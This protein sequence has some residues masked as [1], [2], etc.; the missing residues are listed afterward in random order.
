M[1]ASRPRKLERPPGDSLD[2]R[3][4]VLARVEDDAVVAHA[5][6]AVIETADELP[7]DHEVDVAAPGR[8]QVRVDIERLAHADQAL[9]GPDGAAV[10]SRP[11]DRPEQHGVRSPA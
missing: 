6:R 8:T 9:L 10:P 5:S 11:A 3:R 1:A 4:V 7:D 2:L